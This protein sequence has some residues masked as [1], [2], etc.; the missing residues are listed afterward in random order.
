MAK[1][2]VKLYGRIWFEHEGEYIL[3]PGVVRLIRKVRELGSLKKAAESL[4]MPYRGAWGRIKKAENALGF[5]LLEGTSERQQGMKATAEALEMIEAY[6]ALEGQ[7][8]AFLK[9]K[10]KD[11]PFLDASVSDTDILF[12]ATK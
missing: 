10:S 6:V 8:H 5:P 1:L 9:E 7:L 11:F 4:N 2:P 3:G 12:H